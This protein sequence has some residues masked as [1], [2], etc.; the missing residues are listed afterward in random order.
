MIYKTKRMKKLLYI[1]PM[2]IVMLLLPLTINAQ[3]GRSDG[4]FSDYNDPYYNDRGGGSYVITFGG[5]APGD[6]NSI[7][8]QT[9]DQPLPLGSGLIVMTVAGAGYALLKR[10]KNNAKN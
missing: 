4:L 5:S 3:W 8:N 7:T 1:L 9:F 6:S 10:R 2:V